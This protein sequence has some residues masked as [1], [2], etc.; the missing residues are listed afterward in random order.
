MAI[1]Q[2]FDFMA[3]APLPPSPS[4]PRRSGPGEGG[5]GIGDGT[6]LTKR[7]TE[8][9]SAVLDQLR[10]RIG[11]VQTAASAAAAEIFSTGADSID[12]LLPQGGLPTASIIEWVAATDGCGTSALSLI[13]A[14]AA[15]KA[16]RQGGPLVVVAPPDRFY[17]P[18]AVSLGVPAEQIIWVRPQQPADTV[19]AIDQALRSPAVAVVWAPLASRL[20]DRD[21]R[22]FQLSAETG[23]TVGLLVREPAASRRP[24]FAEVR[25]GVAAV[26]SPQQPISPSASPSPATLGHW[27][28]ELDPRTRDGDFGRLL[29]ISLARC[30]GGRI[31]SSVVVR[32]NDRAEIKQYEQYETTPLPLADHLAHPQR[33]R[34]RHSR[35]RRRA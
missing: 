5:N 11:C 2:T 14:A 8:D 4:P 23:R 25:F 12:G 7:V 10:H 1:Q 16:S 6:P 26:V 20:D 27:D 3:P 28:E 17:P 24:T 9:R 35:G 18:A 15:L 32:I 22:R 29:R 34:A 31:G 33:R 21:A 30:R 19:W 13:T